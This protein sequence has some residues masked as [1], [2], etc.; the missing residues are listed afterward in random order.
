[1]LAAGI[2][3]LVMS[4]VRRLFGSELRVPQLGDNLALPGVGQFVDSERVQLAKAQAKFFR[5]GL[6]VVAAS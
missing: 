1:M 3:I 5:Q 2:I 6:F 4:A